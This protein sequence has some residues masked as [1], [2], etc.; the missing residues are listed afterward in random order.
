MNELDILIAVIVILPVCYFYWRAGIFVCIAAGFLQDT[1]RKLVPGESVY[2]SVMIVVFVA[3]TLLGAYRSS[4]RFT[5]APIHNWNKVLRLPLNLF[6]GL[7]VIQSF[8]AYVKT[9]SLIIAGIGLMAYLTPLPAI[10]LG[11]HF[12]KNEKNII[13]FARVYL[14]IS[15]MMISGVYLSYFGYEWTSL[16]SVGEGLYAF[17]P[18]GDF[19]TLH[20]GFLRSPEIAA[21]HAGTAICF[22]ILLVLIKQRWG[23][24]YWLSGILI[25]FFGVAILLT[26][27]RKF[28]MEIFIFVCGYVV[29][30]IWFRKNA[31][32]S[33]F[34]LVFALALSFLVFTYVLPS[35]FNSGINSYYQRGATVDKD[36]ADRA[37]LM[38]VESFQYVIAENG[39]LGS[40]AGTGS[41]GAQ[42]FGGGSNL[43]GGSA[44][45]GLGKVLA[46]LGV[47]GLA[48]L[49]WLVV[50]FALYVGSILKHV[51]NEDSVR[52]K[53]T[54]W[55]LAFQIANA[56]VY[57]IA[58]QIFGDIFVLVI[59]G[60]SLGF[61]LAIP[62]MQ[63]AP[64]G[65]TARRET[66]YPQGEVIKKPLPI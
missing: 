19:L 3:A 36:A 65:A 44:E 50:S 48:L 22:A 15:L 34:A 46:E 39:F 37:S 66:L 52:A 26:G 47:P 38:T 4:I 2:Y 23:I 55:L 59:L 53:L 7:V 40:G 11:Y 10:L 30:L 43:V 28:L 5:F 6:I 32:Q 8:L 12:G 51:K 33:A 45:G 25:V 62:Q 49:L 13:N 63:K 64:I 21:W 27:R 18:S 58:H 61:I 42:H 14:I 17:S 54:F 31:L 1:I 41:Q 20:S 9:N 56:S 29:L 16:R 60:F 57:V 24:V 35:D